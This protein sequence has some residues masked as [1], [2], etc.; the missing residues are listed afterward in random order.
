MVLVTTIRQ[1]L[2]IAD[3][4]ER[5]A[6]R[7]YEALGACM[8]RVGHADLA[9]VFEALAQEERRHVESVE[10]LAQMSHSS[11]STADIAGITLPETFEIGDAAAAALLTP[12]KALG[13]AVRG[14]ELAFSFWTYVASEAANP[15]VRAQAEAMAR[16]ELVHAAKLRHERRRAYH[17]ERQGR[18]AEAADALDDQAMQ[19]FVALQERETATALH[20]AARYLDG[21]VDPGLLNLIRGFAA[22][23]SAEAAADKTDMGTATIIQRA[24]AVGPVG[25]LFE[26]AGSVEKLIE[27]YLVLL[28]RA[29]HARGQEEVSRRCEKAT[30]A[31]AALNDRLYALEP[32]LTELAHQA[33]SAAQGEARP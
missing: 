28:R 32:S 15:E 24:A 33:P 23:I 1:V 17:A 25:I 26:A 22:S 14:E 10:H 9:R 11:G 16:Q 7:R 18:Q 12:Y 6:V 21:E 31:V 29:E 30:A 19:S 3:A 20:D 27:Q 4:L 13:I 2:T 5:A 8:R